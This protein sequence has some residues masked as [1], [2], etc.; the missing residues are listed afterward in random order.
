MASRERTV[1]M[2]GVSSTHVLGGAGGRPF[3]L[4]FP[5]SRS[6]QRR[7]QSSASFEKP[8]AGRQAGRRCGSAARESSGNLETRHSPV[9]RLETISPPSSHA[10]PYFLTSPHGPA[11]LNVRL[12]RYP[13]CFPPA[14]KTADA[15]NQQQPQHASAQDTTHHTT[16][17][18]SRPR[19]QPR[20]ALPPPWRA[21]TSVR[22]P[23]RIAPC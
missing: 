23:G 18:A 6:L 17:R 2:K 8:C 16:T 15:I 10:A 11:R 3:S 14:A 5:Y 22:P 7:E 12:P 20:L 19:S 21:R 4:A 1:G 9:H 13:R